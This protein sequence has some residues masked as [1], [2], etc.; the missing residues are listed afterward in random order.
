MVFFVLTQ[1]DNLVK[2]IMEAVSYYRSQHICIVAT[3]V[4]IE[5]CCFLKGYY[6]YVSIFGKFAAKRN[7]NTGVLLECYDAISNIK[8]HLFLS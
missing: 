2:D 3:N 6:F 1:T 8:G 4:N 7:R 5:S